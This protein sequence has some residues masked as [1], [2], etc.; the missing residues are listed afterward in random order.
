ME[1]ALLRPSWIYGAGDR[2]M[3]RFVTFVQAE[4]PS[5]LNS[6]FIFRFASRHD[7]E[8]THLPIQIAS[9]DPERFRSA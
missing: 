1:Y 3:N 4:W 6:L 7:S 8:R 5:W 2:S 9:L